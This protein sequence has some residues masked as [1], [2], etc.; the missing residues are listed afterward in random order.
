VKTTE[1]E[2]CCR[3]SLDINIFHYLDNGYIHIFGNLTN[4]FKILNLAINFT[5]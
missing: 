5:R 3:V 1:L 2:H 4:R